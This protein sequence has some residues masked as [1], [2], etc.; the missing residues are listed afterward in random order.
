[1]T[2]RQKERSNIY[3]FLLRNNSARTFLTRGQRMDSTRN[4]FAVLAAPSRKLAGSARRATHFARSRC[5]RPAARLRRYCVCSLRAASNYWLRLPEPSP[6][7]TAP[8]PHRDRL[9]HRARFSHVIWEQRPRQHRRRIPA[10]RT[11]QS[12]T[13]YPPSTP[14]PPPRSCSRAQ[15]AF[16][17]EGSDSRHDTHSALSRRSDEHRRRMFLQLPQ[18]SLIQPNGT[19]RVRYESDTE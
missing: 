13:A 10:L 15:R 1:M 7:A 12:P 4:R 5:A 3:R 17:V 16:A 18:P 2:T 8:Y 11:G 6:T 9:I 14:N 19:E